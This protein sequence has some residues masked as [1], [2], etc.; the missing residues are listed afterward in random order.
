MREESFLYALAKR[1][2]SIEDLKK[3]I[4]DTLFEVE[5]CTEYTARVREFFRKNNLKTT[6]FYGFDFELLRCILNTLY[7]RRTFGG[8][9]PYPTEL[10]GFMPP[11]SKEALEM[12]RS[13]RDRNERMKNAY[14]NKRRGFYKNGERTSDCGDDCK[15]LLQVI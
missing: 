10:F 3:F 12:A 5:D 14:S 8:Y 9:D 11:S 1:G 6:P 7:A 4:D 15:I 13:Y 2:L